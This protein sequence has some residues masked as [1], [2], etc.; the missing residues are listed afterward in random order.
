M[1]SVSHDHALSHVLNE[2]GTGY[3]YLKSIELRNKARQLK[4][5]PKISKFAQFE[6][7][8]FKCKCTVHF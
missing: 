7:Y 4:E 8:W 5:H 3:K 1:K 2:Q 6:G